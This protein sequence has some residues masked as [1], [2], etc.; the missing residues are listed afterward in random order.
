MEDAVIG[1]Q[2]AKIEQF[3]GSLFVVLKTLRYI[4]ETS[5]IETGEVMLFI[6]DLRRHRPSRGRALSRGCARVSSAGPSDYSMGHSPYC[7][8]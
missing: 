6:G 5:D 8:P 4:E 2:R 7:T 1:N 3:E